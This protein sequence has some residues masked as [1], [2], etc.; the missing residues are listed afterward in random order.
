MGHSSIKIT[1]DLYGH[2]MPEVH[3]GAAKKSEDFVFEK[4]NG[5]NTVTNQEKGVIACAVTP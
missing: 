2:V 4:V 3:D 1:L 5:N